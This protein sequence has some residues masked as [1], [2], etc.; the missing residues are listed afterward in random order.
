MVCRAIRG[1]VSSPASIVRCGAERRRIVR[2]TPEEPGETHVRRACCAVCVVIAD[3]PFNQPKVCLLL[4][5]GRI[6]MRLFDV[7]LLACGGCGDL[8]SR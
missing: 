1:F 5:R 3:I 6:D 4:W 8:E 2:N 7:R